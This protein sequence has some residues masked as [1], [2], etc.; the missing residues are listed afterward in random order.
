[1]AFEDTKW[2]MIDFITRLVGFIA[3]V[4]LMPITKPYL[5]S[6]GFLSQD[7]MITGANWLLAFLLAAYAFPKVLIWVYDRVFEE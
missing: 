5:A 4:L 3:A 2:K 7:W 6:A 1:M